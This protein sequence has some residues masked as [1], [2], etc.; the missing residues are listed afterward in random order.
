[1]TGFAAIDGTTAAAR[2]FTLSIK[3]VNHR[4]LD[5]S[6]RIPGGLD[7]LDAP[8]RKAIKASIHRGHVE[9]TLVL[10]RTLV[11]PVVSIDITLLNSYAEA[12][13][14]AAKHLNLQQEPRP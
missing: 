2:S 10:E 5:L 1:M 11:A 4:H 14:Q 12:F 7:A 3:S 13:Q 6:V 8:L 9:L